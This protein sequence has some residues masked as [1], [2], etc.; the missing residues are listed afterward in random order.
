M[1]RVVVA[2]ALGS[3][4][5]DRRAHLEFACQRLASLFERLR[6]SSVLE[7]DPVGMTGTQS[8]FLNQAAVGETDRT[9]RETLEALLAIER[10]RGRE[11][12]FPLAARTLDLDLIL[13]GDARIDERD[14]LE[15]PDLI[16][17]HPRFREREFVLAPLAE[18]AAALVDP[19]TGATVAELLRRVRSRS[20]PARGG[21]LP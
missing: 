7:T 11:R 5:G 12:P 16:V 19:V 20:S 15:G 17:P 6:V 8:R 14:A 2:V 21:R 3:N 13:F 1:D 4:L 9:A 18:I 10:A